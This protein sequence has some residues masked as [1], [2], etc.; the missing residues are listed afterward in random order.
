MFAYFCF[1][2]NFQLLSV[3]NF[4]PELFSELLRK[5]HGIESA[6][7]DKNE[8]ENDSGLQNDHLQIQQK[9]ST[10]IVA[11]ETLL[12]PLNVCLYSCFCFLKQIL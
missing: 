2:W 12:D 5:M 8:R 6:Y 1:K 7:A 4:R 10:T 3:K 11:V 9:L